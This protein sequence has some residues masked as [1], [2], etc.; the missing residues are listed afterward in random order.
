MWGGGDFI[1]G[2]SM[3][4]ESIYGGLFEDENFDLKHD[5]PGVLSMANCGENT[6]GS[7]FQIVLKKFP[8]IVVFGQVINSIGPEVETWSGKP[9]KPVVIA[10]C[11]EL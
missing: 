1:Y 7:Q 4:S 11:G 9:S 2:T 6:N 5:R 3:G 10:E 8:D